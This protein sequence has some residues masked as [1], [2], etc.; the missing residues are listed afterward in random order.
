[1]VVV[2][3]ISSFIVI[4][5][6][7]A[8]YSDII[9]PCTVTVTI[10][11]C[12]DDVIIVTNVAIVTIPT[13]GTS[14]LSKTTTITMTLS[15]AVT[16]T[17]TITSTLLTTTTTVTITTI[18]ISTF[19]TLLTSTSAISNTRFGTSTC[20]Y[21]VPEHRFWLLD[22]LV[23]N[24]VEATRLGATLQGQTRPASCNIETP[25]SSVSGCN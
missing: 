3:I 10:Y 21:N 5:I 2:T 18:A 22:L 16:I 24:F 25:G 4:A 13:A 20:L 12:N 19:I 15:M 7:S 1:M 8:T 14:V 17:I 9:V 6:A 23:T 11:Y